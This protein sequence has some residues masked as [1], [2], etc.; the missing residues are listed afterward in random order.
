MKT[1]WTTENL[2]RHLQ[3]TDVDGGSVEA[4]GL[5]VEMLKMF[6]L[7]SERLLKMKGF[8]RA[9]GVLS[10]ERANVFKISSTSPGASTD[11]IYETNLQ[12]VHSIANKSNTLKQ[13]QKHTPASHQQ[14][15]D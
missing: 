5:V 15:S 12:Y 2:H 11:S 9:G 13:K 1:T 14:F 6:L 10:D 4:T 3:N 8:F 7:S